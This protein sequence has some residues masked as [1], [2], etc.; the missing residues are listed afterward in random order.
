MHKDKTLDNCINYRRLKG[1]AQHTIKTT[2]RDYWQGYCST[3]DR[4]SKLGNVWRMAKKMNGAHTET[5]I[6]NLSVNG[7]AIDSNEEKAELF[8]KSFSDISSTRNYTDKFISHKQNVEHNEAHQFE[9]KLHS[10]ENEKLHNLNEPFSLHE[11]RRA[12]REVKKHTAPGAD[13]IS[14]EMLQ[15]LPKCS[16]KAVLKLYNQIWLN[17]DFPTSWR[18]SIVFPVLKPGKDPQNPASYRPISLT[19]TLC[20]I[21]EKLVTTR[22]TY[23]V[24][25]NNLINNIQC[26]FRKGRSTIDHIIRLQDAIHKHNNNKGYTVGVFIDFKSAFDMMWR[27]GL[28]IKLRNLGITGNIFSFI[29][30]FLTNRSIQ[31]KV[32]DSLSQR[33]VLDNGTAQGSIISPLLFLIMIDDLPDCLEGVESS[34]FADD[35]CIFKSGRNLCQMTKLVQINLDKISDWCDTWGF[36]ISLDKTVAVLFTHRLNSDVHLTIN[37]Q[38]IKT[39]NSAKFL[40]LVFD[41]RLNWNE[42]IKYVENKCKKRLQLMRAVAGNSWGANKKT[43]L[44]IYRSLIRSV[45]DYGS[46]AYNSAS[47]NCKK[48]LDVI[49]HKALRIA[50]GAF[51]TTA[52]SALQVETGE[53]PLALRRSQQEIKYTVKVKATDNHPAKSVTDFHWTTLSRK[54]KFSNPP[55]YA[56]TLEYFL[57]NYNQNV[58]S[59]SLSE[60][61][62]W[63]LKACNVDTDLIDCG[64]KHDNP[65]LL[66]NLALDKIDS[67]RNSILVYTDASKTTDHKATAAFCVPELNIEHSARLTDNITIFTAELTAIK[68]ALL[69]VINTLNKDIS[70]FSDSYSSL[71]AITSGT[72]T[73]RPNLLMEILNLVSNYHKNIT[74]IWIPSHVG[75]KGNESA[76][77]LAN[78]AVLKTTIDVD[79]GLELSEAYSLVD[80]YIIDKWQISWD[81]ESTGS[82][83]RAIEKTV[84]TK[85]KYLHHSRHTDVVITRLR[86]GKCG[87]NAYLHQIGKHPDGLCHSCNKSET[88]SHF[89]IECPHSATC[90]AVLAAC[91]NLGISCTIDKILSDNRIHSA[92]VSSLDKKI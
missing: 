33:Y 38:P 62:P 67:Y 19:T 18:H 34:L 58:K 16:I 10:V 66:K 20:K 22:L 31:V 92:I 55:I 63:H 69:W 9:S 54:F 17:D 32:G 91:K 29:K 89:L 71:Q 13:R 53:L 75:I 24:E 50:C 46:I 40:G 26:G 21:M 2:A 39:E 85:L 8:A 79:V 44:L 76:D 57:D 25:K 83:Y 78:S 73:S 86:L 3:L 14:Y 41:S 28:L 42:H 84:S 43:L 47:E 49:Q 80:R 15:K 60:E 48:K 70:I 81:N 30:N 36:R 56:K 72:S 37:N 51:C 6:L 65:E 12:L 5:K 88:V 74:F 1:K 45:I 68:L 4:S 61:P 87:L 35:S 52:A 7:A 64:S 27:T 23:H 11:L 77:R 82:H 59:P 90:S